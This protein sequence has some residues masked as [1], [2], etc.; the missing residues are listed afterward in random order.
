[1]FAG[2]YEQ[3]HPEKLYFSVATPIQRRFFY[4]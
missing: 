4:R 2:S 3:Q 1:M